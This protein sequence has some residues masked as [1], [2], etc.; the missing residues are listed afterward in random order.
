M[1][2]VSEWQLCTK[3]YISCTFSFAS[4]PTHSEFTLY[5]NRI[6]IARSS[7]VSI[8]ILPKHLLIGRLQVIGLSSSDHH[9]LTTTETK[10]SDR[11]MA[12][13]SAATND[14]SMDGWLLGLMSSWINPEALLLTDGWLLWPQFQNPRLRLLPLQNWVYGFTWNWMSIT[15]VQEIRRNCCSCTCDRRWLKITVRCTDFNDDDD[16]FA[17]GCSRTCNPQ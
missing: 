11:S 8:F 13:S 7:L 5:G 6:E 15:G 2:Y 14:Y 4:P 9:F 10:T 12:R 16:V 1:D 3:I 17:F